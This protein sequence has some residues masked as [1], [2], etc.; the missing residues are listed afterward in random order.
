MGGGVHNQ[1]NECKQNYDFNSHEEL[2]IV[3]VME[4]EIRVIDSENSLSCLQENK[5][6]FKLMIFEL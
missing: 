1:S 4:R 2:E 5:Y 6:L 3:R